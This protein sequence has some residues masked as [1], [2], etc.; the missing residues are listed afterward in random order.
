MFRFKLR[1]LLILLAVGPPMLAGAW[2]TRQKFIERHRRREFEELV[3]LIQPTVEPNPWDDVGGPGSVDEFT[4]N[5]S[6]IVGSGQV[7]H[8][9]PTSNEQ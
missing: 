8:E 9:Q 3:R 5:L 7:V 1:T 4:G 6:I 2:W